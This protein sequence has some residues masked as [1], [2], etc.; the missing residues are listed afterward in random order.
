MCNQ[1]KQK[2][3]E[4]NLAAKGTPMIDASDEEIRS[5]LHTIVI[6][7]G[8]TADQLPGGTNKDKFYAL[9]R[10]SMMNYTAEEI[11]LAFELTMIGEYKAE[12]NHFGRPISILYISN[13]VKAYS[14]Y[15]STIRKRYYIQVSQEKEKIAEE[16]PS[17]GAL[18]MAF[19]NGTIDNYEAYINGE[20][21]RNLGGVY[22]RFIQGLSIKGF[23][24][25][26]DHPDI[27]EKAKKQYAKELEQDIIRLNPSD[28]KGS[29]KMKVVEKIYA[30]KDI[31]GSLL[32]S[33]LNNLYLAGFF[34]WVQSNNVDL[35]KLI[36]EHYK[37][38]KT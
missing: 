38:Y 13:V 10:R 32:S 8:A 17:K 25:D 20:G 1:L 5:V 11:N 31:D 21:I 18:F 7:V 33:T 9:L 23:E 27:I 35:E 36:Q 15:A 12:T 16:V 6:Y 14:E 37:N 2:C 4:L 19:K 30:G 24:I 34:K 26:I 29:V 28:P 3:D 22:T